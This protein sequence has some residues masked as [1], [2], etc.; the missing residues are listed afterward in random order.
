MEGYRVQFYVKSSNGEKPVENFLKD[1]SPLVQ[2]KINKYIELLRVSNGYLDEP[3][4]RHITGKIRELRV[5][6]KHIRHRVFY[7]TFIGQR[8][9]LLH[10]FIK[11][12]AKTPPAEINKALNYY[13]DFI[14]HP[15]LYE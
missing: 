7:F 8:I 4:S 10:G 2:A 12:T 9:I 14:S 5:D 15:Y 1:L 3:L 11:K 6:F 13:N